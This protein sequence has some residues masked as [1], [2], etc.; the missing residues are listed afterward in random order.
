MRKIIR[1]KAKVL[2]PALTLGK[3]S[4]D[5]GSPSL[6]EKGT[7]RPPAGTYKKKRLGVKAAMRKIIEDD[8]RR[9]GLIPASELSPSLR[10]MFG[11]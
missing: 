3:V 7:G 1:P 5:G 9:R 8:E 2:P 4:S 10:R 6:T 11:I